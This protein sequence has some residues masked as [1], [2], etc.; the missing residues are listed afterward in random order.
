MPG[1]FVGAHQ[2]RQVPF[3]P[4]IPNVGLLLRRCSGKGLHH[5][6]TGEP[7]GFSRVASGF[8]RYDG[9]F[10]MPLVS[11]LENSMDRGAWKATVHGV[12]DMNERLSLSMRV[13]RQL[14]SYK[15]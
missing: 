15:K 12:A 10:R 9:E 7:R 3:R 2:G 11:G 5:A 4:P 14:F 13:I 1:N 6:M 8:S